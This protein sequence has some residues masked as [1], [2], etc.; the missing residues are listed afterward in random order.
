MNISRINDLDKMM[1]IKQIIVGSDD[2]EMVDRI[3]SETKGKIVTSIYNFIEKEEFSEIEFDIID[4]YLLSKSC[5]VSS[6]FSAYSILAGI[7]EGFVHRLDLNQDLERR[8]GDRKGGLLSREIFRVGKEAVIWS[9]YSYVHRRMMRESDFVRAR[10]VASQM[11][12]RFVDKSEP[13]NLLGN[14]A[15]S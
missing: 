12:E 3:G 13:K 1:D 7:I 8:L 2:P 4:L 6:G 15:F 5:C 14:L 10:K 11:E 9:A